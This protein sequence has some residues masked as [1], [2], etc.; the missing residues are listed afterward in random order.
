MTAAYAGLLCNEHSC[1]LRNAV[2]MCQRC[3]RLNALTYDLRIH[4]AVCTEN[5]AAELLS[6]L[7]VKEVSALALHFLLN[8]LCHVLITDDGLLRSTD[9]SVVE[10]LGIHD[11]F[12][13]QRKITC[14]LKISRTV[15]RSNA[16]CRCSGRICCLHHCGTT[17]CKD[18]GN[19]SVMH[20]CAGC[21]HRRNADAGYEILVCACLGDC[22]TDYLHGLHN[23]TKCGRM[24]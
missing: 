13:C 8:C 1:I 9:G 18:Q 23:R 21:F 12:Y 5:K 17:G 22:L 6:L 2:Q 4:C 20:Q 24:R 14:L 3:D 16:D 15:S 19:I 10:C 11:T 7:L